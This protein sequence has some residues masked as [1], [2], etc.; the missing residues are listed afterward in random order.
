MALKH[1]GLM[2]FGTARWIQG[3]VVAFIVDNRMKKGETAEMKLEL[4]GIPDTVLANIEIIQVKRDDLGEVYKYAARILEMSTGDRDLLDSW[5][6]ERSMGSTSFTAQRTMAQM[7]LQSVSGVQ[8][9]RGPPRSHSPSRSPTSR[10]AVGDSSPPDSSQTWNPSNAGPGGEKRGRARINKALR[11]RLHPD[12]DE[13]LRPAQKVQQKSVA[14]P[15]PASQSASGVWSTSSVYSVTNEASQETVFDPLVKWTEG[16]RRADVTW[17]EPQNLIRDWQT[18]LCNHALPLP[19]KLPHPKRGERITLRLKLP[20][21]QVLA[22]R[23]RV[24]GAAGRTVLCAIELSPGAR[25][26]LKKAARAAALAD[27]G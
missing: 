1:Q 17:L 4:T 26:K 7:G 27:Q 25:H 8:S 18:H 3:E 5:I 15:S 6:E 9:S 19:M 16:E 12:T 20:D 23:S 21:G 13:G 22:L 14:P 2:S 24:V 10:Y 11:T